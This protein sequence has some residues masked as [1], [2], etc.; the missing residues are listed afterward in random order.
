MKLN[1]P[2]SKL[3]A[4]D[5]STEYLQ[6][7]LQAGDSVQVRSLNEGLKQ[8][9]HIKHS[10][11][12]MPLLQ[13]LLTEM[14]ILPSEL[15]GIICGRGPGSFMGLRIGMSSLKALSA[16]L[17]IPLLSVSTLDAIA[18]HE[19]HTFD[20]PSS[21]SGLIVPVIDARGNH[22]YTCC[23]SFDRVDRSH[24]GSSSAEAGVGTEA[25]TE[26]GSIGEAMESGRL[27]SPIDASLEEIQ[28]FLRR[29]LELMPGAAVMLCGPHAV[30]L[31][32][33]L[34]KSMNEA[35]N[36]AG[37]SPLPLS[38]QPPG[39]PRP[40]VEAMIEIGREAFNSGRRDRPEQGPE[41]IRPGV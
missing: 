14:A 31:Y 16:V 2:Y 18:W 20:H 21:D 13:S 32:E 28:G 7:A 19:R 22:F 8:M 40:W 17:D 9:K 12:L 15:H 33:A 27:G 39:P 35:M 4:V 37:A 36:V 38:I 3:L 29:K 10:E 30:K 26:G 25:G 34:N 11:R 5:S 24:S 41:Y 1:V 23:Y 6:L